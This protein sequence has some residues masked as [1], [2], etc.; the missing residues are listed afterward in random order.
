MR[1][2][3]VRSLS[4]DYLKRSQRALK[5]D[6]VDDDGL[7][8]PPEDSNY[9]HWSQKLRSQSDRSHSNY[10]RRNERSHESKEKSQISPRLLTSPS[11]RQVALARQHVPQEMTVHNHSDQEINHSNRN[12]MQLRPQPRHINEHSVTNRPSKRPVAPNLN[13]TSLN[14]HQQLEASPSVV[15]S[16]SS[17]SSQPS[18]RMMTIRQS[19]S[20]PT[21]AQSIQDLQFAHLAQSKSHQ[22]SESIVSPIEQ[23]R[24]H[25]PSPS[26]EILSQRQASSS[27]K[28]VKSSTTSEDHWK[29]SPKE[30]QLVGR[31][32]TVEEI[33]QPQ[34]MPNVNSG[35]VDPN[36]EVEVDLPS[37]N[38][39]VEKFYRSLQSR[40]NKR[41]QSFRK[42]LEEEL[43]ANANS[44]R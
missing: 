29:R 36:H 2:S 10:Q 16:N 11:P 9:S 39:L 35:D 19:R 38:A 1:G 42:R 33:L 44:S 30:H 40:S 8:E 34:L 31:R 26:P 14:L 3:S 43:S 23:I 32:F 21:Q 5:I 18:R 25:S 6:K 27:R 12:S 4:A 24:T 37:I 41:I 20:S 15:P 17:P 28:V 13:S 22:F 7:V